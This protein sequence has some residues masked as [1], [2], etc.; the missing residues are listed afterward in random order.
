[1]SAGTGVQ[2]YGKR[3]L[4]ALYA[5]LRALK[6]YPVENAAVQQALDE[7]HALAVRMV[8]AE[9][10][11]ELRVVGEF[12]FLNETRLRLDLSNF[13][14][15]GSFAR[16]LQDHGI[17]SVE[18]L[19]GVDRDQWA[20][21]LSLLLRK[22][23]PDDPYDIFLARLD[24]TPVEHIHTRPESEV[25]EEETEE[26]LH[27]A[28]RTYVQSVQAAKEALG[29]LRLGRAV[30]VR[31][32]KRAV[33][34]IVDQVLSNEPSIITMTT[35]RDYDE[36]TFTHCV[37]V[38]IFSVVIGQ[39]LGLTKLQLYELGL[40]ALL[41]DIG[42]TRIDFEIINKPG[43]LSDE[44]WAL[45]KEHT[46][47]GL[48]LLFQM[49]GFSDV[50]YR[51]MLMAYEHHMKGSGAGYPANRRSRRIGLFSR[52]VAVA[53]GF[54]AGTS[55]RSYQYKP[56]PADAV[57]KEMRDNPKRGY[58]PLLVKAL[59]TSTG[60]FP[61]GTLVILDTMEMAVVAQVNP[62]PDKL[63]LPRVKVISDEMGI[64]LDDPVV[65]DLAQ[66]PAGAT[67]TILKTTDP[68]K[69]GIQVSDYLI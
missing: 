17:G 46:T 61:V 9:S 59:I 39:R 28:K 69:Y 60:V 35:L 11:M 12:F 43:G 16:S 56:W 57:L 33:Q 52:I 34:N 68:Q 19:P 42:K 66:Q 54:D 26:A 41:H 25:H 32:V 62:D 63:H 45:M 47:E 58:D 21:F 40:G 6:L 64:P 7:L 49:A 36:Y 23:D 65:L 2:A 20:P 10:G 22:P 31:R 38:C 67:R 44:E 15:F 51:Q 8:E 1:M 3:L 18:V 37:N 53:D 13:A 14:T 55:V 5:A 29:D 24:A 50:P 30:N 4:G 48:L 27:A